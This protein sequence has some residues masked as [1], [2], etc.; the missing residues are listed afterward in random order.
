M[1]HTISVLAKNEAGVLSRITNLFSSRG[2]NIESLT[3]ANTFD[4]EYS[5]ATIVTYGD[6]KVIEQIVKQLHRLIPIIKVTEMNSE[7]S[8]ILELVF[9]KVIAKDS[10]AV[11]L[12]KLAESFGG[13]I[14]NIYQ[15]E[16]TIQAVC[17]EKQLKS[18]VELLKPI[19]I[20]DI[21]H[22]GSVAI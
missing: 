1:K 12:L 19:G 9:I 3:V 13:K 6:D 10:E 15:K 11:E 22:S 17:D 2:Y 7:T 4:A 20:K 14:I 16:Y 18:L 21:V 5:R 8:T